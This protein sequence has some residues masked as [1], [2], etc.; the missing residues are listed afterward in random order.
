MSFNE[1]LERA[2][3]GAEPAVNEETGALPD[4]MPGKDKILELLKSLKALTALLPEKE[5]VVYIG[6]DERLRLEL[7]IEALEGRVGLFRMIEEKHNQ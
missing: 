3:A 7:L 4:A 6:S 1:A 5:K 2:N